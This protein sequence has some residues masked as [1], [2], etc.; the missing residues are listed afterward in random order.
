MEI[1]NKKNKVFL[2]KEKSPKR[3]Q[4]ISRWAGWAKK[5]NPKLLIVAIILLAYYF[6]LPENLFDAPTATVV[7]SRQG[8]LLGAIIADD[9]QW[10]FPVVDS[11]P[12]KFKICLLQ[13]EDAYFYRHPGFNPV[14][15]AKAFGANIAVGKNVRGGSTITQQV[16]RLSR[17]GQK[18]SYWEKAIELALATRLEL[19]DSKEEILRL[20]TSHAPYGGNVV[21]LDV[22]SWRY[23]G[24]R[25]HQLSW[26]EAATLAILPNAPSLIYPGKNQ[27]ELLAKRNRLLR[28]LWTEKLID[29]T[30]YD[31]AL[32]EALPQKPYPLP[33]TASHLVQH[34]A[35]NHRGKRI[36]STID[37]NLQ[38]QVNA[39]IQKHHRNLR[40]NQVHN[41]ALM[42]MDVK[43]RQVLSY[44][45]NAPT[46]AEHQKDVDMVQANRSTGSI[47]KP[48]LYA[49]MLDAGE[50]LPN[51]L[52][53]DV[54]TQIAGYTPENFNEDYAGAVPAKNALARSLNIPAV[55]LLQQYGLEKFRDQLDVFGLH[56]LD[57][58][59]D[60]YDLPLFWAGPKA[61]FGTCVRPTRIWLPPSTIST[62]L[63]ANISRRNLPNPFCKPTGR[64]ISDKNPPKKRSSMPV[65]FT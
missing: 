25:P 19:R 32:L 58:S 41:V 13:F 45:G 22:A 4:D 36:S 15:M 49:A 34:M 16:I 14:S 51:M 37:E 48:L 12:Y 54:P 64:S 42:V 5:H 47:I 52:I 1:E 53:P 59:A 26:A 27:D 57:K 35:K 6:C 21:G 30:T 7:E 11:V 39:I 3:H 33:K 38:G 60:H 10:R 63:Q 56:G 20:Y 9:G 28:K 31:L 61:V 24:L 55:R 17:D 40:Q 43:T 44:V 62:A 65:V 50:L 29:T 23:F 18:R 2:S 8:T 46:T